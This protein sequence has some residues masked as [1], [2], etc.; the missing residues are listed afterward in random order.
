LILHKKAGFTLHTWQTLDHLDV[1]AGTVSGM[2]TALHAPEG[3]NRKKILK[4][5]AL[6]AEELGRT[7]DQWIYADQVHGN[8]SFVAGP[9]HRGLGALDSTTAIPATDAIILGHPGLQAMIF[10]ADCLPVILFDTENKYA[11]LIHAGW[12]GIAGGI[13]PQVLERMCSELHSHVE[14]IRVVAGPAVDSCCYQIDSPVYD[15]LTRSYPETLNAF[16]KDG[17]THWRLSLE[18]AVFHQLIAKGIK[19]T[20]MEGSNLCSC[21][22][23]DLYSWRREGS[24]CG[25]MATY[26]CT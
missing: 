24:G 2:N 9:E 7:A 1:K 4:N 8:R 10:T 5:R 11:A 18:K 21:C 19:E 22:Q 26:I 12:R 17:K 13:V 20:Q 14:N 16:K 6:L 23:T 3:V 15:A 25:R